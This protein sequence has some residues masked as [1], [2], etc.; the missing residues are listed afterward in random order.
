MNKI[1]QIR[2]LFIFAALAF[3]GTSCND[4]PLVNKAEDDLFSVGGTIANYS[5][6]TNGGFYNLKDKENTTVGFEISSAGEPING[7]TVKK[8]FNGGDEVEY[9]TYNDLPA[10][11]DVSLVEAISGLGVDLEDV[12]VGNEVVYTF[13]DSS[14][15]AK[16]AKSLTVQCSCPSDFGGIFTYES[17]SY[18][19]VSD[20]SVM[21]TV[22]ITGIGGGLYEID[23]WD[24]GAYV[25][26]YPE[27]IT[28]GF[29]TLQLKDLC[30][31][32]SVIGEDGY[33]DG[34]AWTIDEIAGRD[35]TVSWSND[36]GENGTVIIS[37]SEDQ[38][39]WPP[40]FTN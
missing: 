10:T 5:N 15:G 3:V 30:E 17:I 18:W 23:N 6:V 21:D 19:C 7:I 26:C 1:F 35:M 8:S 11:L 32:I 37:R 16:F 14:T 20:T 25:S 39:D 28:A 29:G 40:L 2:N 12:S 27:P 31:E 24:F 36:Y 13:Y 4:E 34:W 38:G 33:G 9:G 22:A